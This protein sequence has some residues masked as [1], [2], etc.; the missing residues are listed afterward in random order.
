MFITQGLR[1]AAQINRNGIATIDGERRLKWSEFAERVAR[2]AGALHGLGL[3]KGGHIAILA[4]NSDRYLEYFF[5]VPWAGGVIVPLNTRLALPELSYMLQ[6]AEVTTLVVDEA[7][8]NMAPI[9]MANTPTVKHLIY[10]DDFDVPDGLLSHESLVSAAQP[11]DDQSE[12]ENDV[13]GIFYTGGTTGLPKG[14]ML[15]HRNLVNNALVVLLNIY[16]GTPMTYLHS[17]PMF[18]IADCQWNMGVTLHGGTHVFMPKFTPEQ[19]LKAVENYHITHCALVPT[20]VNMLCNFSGRE[21]YDVSTLRG[22]NYGGSP[23]PPALIA[24]AREAFPHWR[25]FQ[26]YGQTETSPNISMLTDQYHVIE[27]PNLAKVGSAGQPVFTMEVRI[28]GPEDDELPRGEIGEIVTRGPNVMAGYWNKPNETAVALR[29]GWM[30]TGDLGYMDEDGF[31]YIVDRLK[32]MI[33][34]GGE[35]IYSAEVESVIYQH[36]SVAVCAVF[37]IP[38]DKWGE[39]VHAVILPKEGKSISTDEIVAFCRERIA[40]YKCPKSVEIRTKPLPMSGAG[41]ILK[42]DLRQPYWEGKERAVN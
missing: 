21:N 25:F 26:G 10:A 7:H 29:G 40:S 15:T 24:R 13:V 33:I 42:R 22:I 3:E 31:V 11:I 6:D 17:A 1:R 4:F 23:M 34:S 9:I 28:V 36:P 35:N 18:H 14:V 2:L 37:G 5:A 8:K 12:S 41:K 32:D 20:M 16:E 19:M 30:H 39:A 27:G 38:D